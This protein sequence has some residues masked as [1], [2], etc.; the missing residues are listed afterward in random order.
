MSQ[1]RSYLWK[2]ECEARCPAMA[3][4]V[5]S[6]CGRK[7]Q[8]CRHHKNKIDVQLAEGGWEHMDNPV[9]DVDAKE[10]VEA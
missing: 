1:Y 5:T 4:A 3:V 9:D 8:L 6:I 10:P 2:V 7:F